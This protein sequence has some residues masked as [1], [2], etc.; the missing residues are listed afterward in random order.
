M[1]GGMSSANMNNMMMMST[2]N[3]SGPGM[4]GNFGAAD[5]GAGAGGANTHAAAPI[6]DGQASMHIQA[7]SQESKRNQEMVLSKLDNIITSVDEQRVWFDTKLC[8]LER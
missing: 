5:A 4:T 3:K 2:M 8:S 7:T 6:M 1:T